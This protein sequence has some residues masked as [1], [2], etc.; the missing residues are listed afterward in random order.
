MFIKSMAPFCILAITVFLRLLC[1]SSSG[2]DGRLKTST[3]SVDR[4]YNMHSLTE[5]EVILSALLFW[6]QA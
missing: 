3:K 1:S 4:Q 2:Q 6:S 5:E